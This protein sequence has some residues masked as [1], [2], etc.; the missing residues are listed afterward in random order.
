MSLEELS[1]LSQIISAAVVVA[2][3]I[4]VGL[5]LILSSVDTLVRDERIRA[6]KLAPPSRGQ[7]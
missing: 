4:F 6:H 1:F 7:S 3:L 2:S 5:Q